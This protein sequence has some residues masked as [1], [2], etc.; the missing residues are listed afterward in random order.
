[1]KLF[2]VLIISLLFSTASVAEEII[3]DSKIKKVTVFLKGAQINREAKFSI[4]PGVHEIIISG[5]SQYVDPQSI[6][7]KGTNG[8]IIMDSKFTS[9]YPTPDEKEVSKLPKSVQLKINAIEDSLAQ[10][11]FD[12]ADLNAEL[13]V[14]NASKSIIL[15]N[16]SMRGQGRVND[17]IQLLKE[18]VEYYLKK[19]TILNK[20]MN[21]ISRVKRSKTQHQSELQKRLNELRNYSNNQAFQ[22]NGNT[23]EYRIVVTVSADKITTG[24]LDLT[25]L[26]N[27]AGW[28]AQYDLRSNIE[29]S[30]INLNYKA[31]VYQNTGIDWKEVRLS[32]S[33]NDPYKNKTKPELSPW[34]IGLHPF[35][36]QQNQGDLDQ[37]QS[38]S[39]IA[40]PMSRS[41]L[42]KDDVEE[43]NFNY[44]TSAQHTQVIQHMIS[45]EFKIDLPY[46]IKSNGE[47]HM[48]LVK[49]EDVEANFIYYAVPKIENAAYLVA[50][51]TN[52]E[53]LQMIPAKATIFFDGSYMGET[54]INPGVMDDTLSLSLGKD[55]NIIVKRTFMKK[56][57]KEKIIGSDV[58]KTS[59]YQIEILNNKNK[60]IE[61]IVQDQIPVSRIEGIEI[62]A[63]DISNGKLIE[64]TGIIEW[65]LNI[66][67]KE[68]Q[69]L[70][71][72]YKVKH[73]EKDPLVVR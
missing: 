64:T 1:M 4:N 30:K 48:V 52:M 5:V 60:S 24:Y 55:P 53:E 3:K 45:A 17:S 72:K 39:E 46:T 65:K 8:I 6:Q 35:A 54:F 25:Y 51:I 29:S 33:T 23:S 42:E 15:N 43:R 62:T 49:N 21:A 34:L 68:K 58:E 9:Y 16:G 37:K 2:N 10:I 40:V 73:N 11:A 70:D 63:E 32:V 27:N 47:K 36:Y 7:I 38:L 31:Q 41:K 66:E 19:V 12:L 18:A 26:V 67:S 71:L 57:Y 14:V 59:M 56:K 44:A 50:R 28:T 13:E 69:V 22:K 20:E 61:I